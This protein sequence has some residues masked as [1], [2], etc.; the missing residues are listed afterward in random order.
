VHLFGV[1]YKPD[2]TDYRESPAIDVAELLERRGAIVSYT[3]PYVPHLS[4]EHGHKERRELPFEQA[5][6]QGYDCAVITT[7]HKAFDY[8]AIVERSP[9][10]LDTRNALKGMTAAHVYRL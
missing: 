5:V 7:N 2:V 4:A 10:V 1:A 8:E 9:L 3:D 6:K